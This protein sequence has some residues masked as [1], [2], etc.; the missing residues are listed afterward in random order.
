[1]NNNEEFGTINPRENAF[2]GFKHEVLASFENELDALLSGMQN[3]DEI[4]V[5]FNVC[6]RNKAGENRYD[7]TISRKSDREISLVNTKTIHDLQ[8][9]TENKEEN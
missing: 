3:E 1:M 4:S 7:S 8:P 5:E 2:N 6:V 9:V